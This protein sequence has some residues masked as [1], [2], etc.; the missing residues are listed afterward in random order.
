VI[1]QLR[2]STRSVLALAVERDILS[3]DPSGFMVGRNA[4]RPLRDPSIGVKAWSAVEAQL[5]LQH[6]V[7]D[8][9][10]AL[11]IL[12]LGSG[13][14]RGEALGLQWDDV[15]FS[16]RTVSVSRSLGLLNGVPT[17]SYPKTPNSIRTI[18]VGRS[19]IDALQ[20]HRRRQVQARLES[21][22]WHDE[23]G[24]IFTNHVGKRLRPDHVTRRLKKLVT[25]ADLPWITVHGLRHSMASIAL[26]NGTDIATVSERLG[27]ADAGITT[28]IYVH[29]SKESD[30]T[31]ADVLDAALHG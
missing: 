19:V 26:Q 22:S 29:G 24:M 1:R 13:L 31:A 18:T 8:R 10:E 12:L 16:N 7:G 14:R 3:A 9:F 21:D 23:E 30:R 25:E 27:H 15:D 20:A 5:F 4:P 2:A 28:R 11:W 6:V 17:M